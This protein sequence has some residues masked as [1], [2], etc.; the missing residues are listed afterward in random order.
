M[1]MWNSPAARVLGS[2]GSW[3]AFVF[4][5][6]LLFRTASVVM[7]LGGSCASGGPYVIEVE[8]PDA[9]LLFAPLSI[10]GLFV[11]AGI[12]LALARGFGTPLILWGW[13]ILFVGLG[14]DFLLASFVPGGIANLVVAIVF[15]AMGLVPLIVVLRV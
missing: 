6:T 11:A 14:I 2:A 4:C 3:F 12:A 15:I 9:V 13:P 7:G 10:V 8:C 1:Q 5:F